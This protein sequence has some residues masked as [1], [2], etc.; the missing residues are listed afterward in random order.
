MW[1]E[2]KSNGMGASVGWG[3]ERGRGELVEKGHTGA[4]C[5]LKVSQTVWVLRWGGEGT[6]GRGELVEKGSAAKT[7]E[8]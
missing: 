7:F 5:G 4:V 6:G 3:G 8:P 1:L 2:G